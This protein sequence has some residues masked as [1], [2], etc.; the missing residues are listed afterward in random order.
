MA[1]FFFTTDTLSPSHC[2]SRQVVPRDWCFNAAITR[3][4]QRGQQLAFL[5]TPFKTEVG[6]L[7]R[8]LDLTSSHSSTPSTLAGLDNCLGA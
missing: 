7:K 2:P 1:F 8:R 5:F 6:L 4:D 3:F